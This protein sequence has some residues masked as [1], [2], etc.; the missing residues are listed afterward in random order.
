MVYLLFVVV[1]RRTS[2]IYYPSPTLNKE[3]DNDEEA[4]V[5]NKIYGHSIL[6]SPVGTLSPGHIFENTL[7]DGITSSQNG[8]EN[9]LYDGITSSQNGNAV[10]I[11]EQISPRNLSR[12]P[13]T[14]SVSDNESGMVENSAYGILRRQNI[15]NPLYGAAAANVASP[16]APPT[17]DT[18]TLTCVSPKKEG[19]EGKNE[20]TTIPNLASNGEAATPSSASVTPSTTPSSPDHE[21]IELSDRKPILKLTTESP[22]LPPRDREM[23]FNFADNLSPGAGE[24][25][26]GP[27]HYS[28]LQHT[29]NIVKKSIRLAAVVESGYEVL[30]T[31]S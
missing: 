14:S 9:V 26:P 20:Y 30:E 8:N 5:S 11:Y 16:H 12:D 27:L 3:K 31:E 21:S 29:Q 13:E 6:L 4:M 17:Y 15:N 2:H 1:E 24:S 18:P 28:K 22:E 19:A 10:I 7:Y 25:L 23:V